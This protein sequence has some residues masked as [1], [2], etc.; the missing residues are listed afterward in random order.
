MLDIILFE[1]PC[2]FLKFLGFVPLVNRSKKAESLNIAGFHCTCNRFSSKDC[3][4]T[5][6]A[7]LGRYGRFDGKKENSLQ[8]LRMG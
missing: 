1:D 4:A 6:A 7:I 8:I 5:R 3:R 2:N